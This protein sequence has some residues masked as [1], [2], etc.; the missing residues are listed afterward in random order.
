MMDTQA[1]VTFAIATALL[2]PLF[3]IF[4]PVGR[5]RGQRQKE[6]FALNLGQNGFV[7]TLA[8]AI[9]GNIGIGSFLALFLF[10]KESPVIGF[11]I[12]GA[13]TIGLLICAALACRIRASAARTNAVGLIDLIASTHRIHSVGPIWLPIAIVFVLRSAVQLGALGYITASIFNGSSELAIAACAVVIGIYLF[14]GGY[15]AAVQTDIAQAVI[16]VIGCLVCWFGLGKLEGSPN[17][18]LSFGDY[19]P[20]LLLGIWLFI[21]WSAV[22]AV[23]NWQRVTLAQSTRTAGAAYVLAALVCGSIFFL[24]ALAGYRSE[25]GMTM[26]DAFNRLLPVE[27]GW[28]AIMMFVACIMSSI[29][30]FIMPLVSAIGKTPSIARMRL[31]IVVLVTATAVTAVLFSDTLETVI[32][33]F[34]SLTVFLPAA[35]GALFMKKAAPAAAIWSL[36]TG[37]AAAVGFTFIDQNSA[38]LIGFVTAA[39]VYVLLSLGSRDPKSAS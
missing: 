20:V 19:K 13:Y 16:I 1:T 34:N 21:P 14:L 23:D 25:N 8:G 12:A 24:I 15:R 3:L 5:D 30:T 27:T 31:S 17:P 2:L 7:A 11:S 38:S 6:L 35:M 29:D 22:L 36:N 18:F 37:L 32:T 26:Y 28:L 33:A 9:A 4:I 39:V 10:S